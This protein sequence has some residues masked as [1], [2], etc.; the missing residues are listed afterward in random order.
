MW[1]IDHVQ[2]LIGTVRSDCSIIQFSSV[3]SVGTYYTSFTIPRGKE[4][5][6]YNLQRLCGND[7]QLFMGGTDTPMLHGLELSLALTG[8][9]KHLG[10]SGELFKFGSSITNGIDAAR[11]LPFRLEEAIMDPLF[12]DGIK[13]LAPHTHPNLPCFVSPMGQLMWMHCF[14]YFKVLCNPRL[15][16]TIL[17]FYATRTLSVINNYR[18]KKQKIMTRTNIQLSI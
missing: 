5:Q 13:R 9:I 1:A 18:G 17:V 7:S 16:I 4:D 8:F 3:D 2:L 10:S 15:F 14:L 6:H 12:L 11:R